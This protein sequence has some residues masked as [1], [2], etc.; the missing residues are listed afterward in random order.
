VGIST[1]K[2][3]NVDDVPIVERPNIRGGTLLSR[4]LLTG[5]PGTP[6]NFSLQLSSTPTY[7]SPRHRHNFD[8]V[9][10]QLAGDF[11]FSTD[12]VMKPGSVAYFPEGTYYG[13]QQCESGSETLVLQFGGASR[14]GYLSA[15]EHERAAADLAGR[16][17][18]SNGVYTRLKPD[19]GKINKDA[20][21]AVWEQVN[22]RSLE[23]PGQ[24]YLRP[25]FMDPE[26]FD[27]LPLA[28]QPG[29]NCKHLGEF[30]ELR[31][32][33]SLF[34]IAPGASLRLA[35]HSICF[36]A[37]GSGAAGGKQFRPQATIHV[38]AGEQGTI[39]AS[40]NGPVELL[41]IGLPRFS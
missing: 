12:G 30:S 19:G 13:P 10:F 17:A 36:V 28:D 16:G 21:E 11:D 40:A 15:E 1:V 24:R 9:R 22:G 41:Q 23:Y 35:D 32:R 33:L 39:A 38:G 31:T 18:F 26:N 34:R 2:V 7:Y 4:R 25:V 29:A 8:Q 27:W 6:G 20:Y 3:I 14:S 5:E 37:S